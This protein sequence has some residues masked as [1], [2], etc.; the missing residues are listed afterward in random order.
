MIDFGQSI[1]N[2]QKK[3]IIFDILYTEISNLKK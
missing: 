1:F 3:M 2:Q